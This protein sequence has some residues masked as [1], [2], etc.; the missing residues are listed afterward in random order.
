MMIFVSTTTVAKQRLR[1]TKTDHN[2]IACSY[3]LFTLIA[4]AKALIPA[5]TTTTHFQ[6]NPFVQMATRSH[7]WQNWQ[8]KIFTLSILIDQ[9]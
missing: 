3:C 7:G 2:H 4:A 1:A 8:T 5:K 9:E 6:V